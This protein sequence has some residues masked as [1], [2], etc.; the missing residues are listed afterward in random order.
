[1]SLTRFHKETAENLGLFNASTHENDVLRAQEKVRDKWVAAKDYRAVVT[2]ILGNWTSG[3]CIDF[4]LPVSE[5]LLA[6][7]EHE[8]HHQLWAR[9]IKRQADD[10][11]RNYSHIRKDKRTFEEIVD[12]DSSHFDEF[13]HFAYESRDVATSFLLKRLVCSLELWRQSLRSRRLET[14][15][16]D[17]IERDVR[18]LKKPSIHVIARPQ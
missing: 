10:A 15:E 1:M 16:I 2:A 14:G 9:T 4:M 5:A 12:I 8:L 18:A 3:N 7:G 13:N 6:A 17:R 11:F